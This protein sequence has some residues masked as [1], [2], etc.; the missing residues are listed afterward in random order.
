MASFLDSLADTVPQLRA[1]LDAHARREWDEARAAYLDLADQ[2]SLTAIALHQLGVIA[3]E[4]GDHGRAAALFQ[5]ALRLDPQRPIFHQSLGSALERLGK[6]TEALEAIMGFGYVLHGAGQDELAIA[7]YRR[8]LEADRY[9][10][11][12]YFN[13]GALIVATDARAGIPYLVQGIA[14]CTWHE[15]RLRRL[16]DRLLPRLVGDGLV[17]REVAAT[18]GIAL[19][20]VQNLELAV[21]NLGVGLGDLGMP[22]EAV[23]CHRLAV[24]LDPGFPDAHFNLSL[25][26]LGAGDLESGWREY[27]W[28]WRWKNFTA[29][30]RR[31]PCARWQGQDIAGKTIL[32]YGEQGWGDVMQFAPLVRRLEAARHVVLE[33]GPP[34]VALF[35]ENF[36]HGNV[37]VISC[38]ANPDRVNTERPLDYAVPLLSMPERLGLRLH[39]LPLATAYLRANAKKASQWRTRLATGAGL[40]VGIAW[41]GS[42]THKNDRN[43]SVALERLR[44]IFAVAGITWYSLQIGARANEPA[45]HGLPLSDLSDGLNDFVDTAAAITNLDLV[46]SVDTSVAHLAAALGKPTWILLPAV[47]DW[48]WLRVREDSPWYPGVR[49]FRQ[50][51]L[52]DWEAVG[53]AVADALA[54]CVADRNPASSGFSKR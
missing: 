43:R 39:D 10:Y 17:S 46:I 1:A 35:Q 44:R 26:L 33:V 19:G 48:R 16:L 42:P 25:Q 2:P 24:E 5:S 52:G 12:A 34:L 28:R 15:P 50:P 4:Q 53:V 32:V 47:A 18:T 29:P 27:E 37:E 54:R 36:A 6:R 20:R 41:A 21:T 23:A 11:E 22:E 7:S 8:V 14:L 51:V 49:L 30:R 13:L 40:K 31:L 3:T 9:R 45:L 38:D